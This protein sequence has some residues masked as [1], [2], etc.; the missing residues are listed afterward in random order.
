MLD[1]L[2]H[3]GGVANRQADRQI[4]NKQGGQMQVTLWTRQ[5]LMLGEGMMLVS[6][7]M[8]MLAMNNAIG[9]LLLLLLNG[10]RFDLPE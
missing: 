4:E 3:A 1:R 6:V 7:M 5:T 10:L 8:M 2:I 9:R